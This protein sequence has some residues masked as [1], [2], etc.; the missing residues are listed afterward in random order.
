MN[1]DLRPV[2]KEVVGILVRVH[3]GKGTARTKAFTHEGIRERS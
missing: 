1:R 2:G 3:C